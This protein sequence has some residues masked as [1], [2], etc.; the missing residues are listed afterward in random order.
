MSLDFDTQLLQV[1]NNGTL[2]G[3]AEICVL[4]CDGTRL[5]T[6]V[7]EN[8]LKAKRRR[9]ITG[10]ARLLLRIYLE[11]TFSKELISGSERNLYDGTKL[12]HL[13]CNVVFDVCKTLG[14]GLLQ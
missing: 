6:N 3:A 1:L 7:V 2:D 5:V 8:I 4:I 12:R 13:S 14:A 11:T 10:T 9:V